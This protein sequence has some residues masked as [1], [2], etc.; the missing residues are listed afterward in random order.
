MQVCLAGPHCASALADA[1]SAIERS[2]ADNHVILLKD[3]AVRT[4]LGLFALPRGPSATNSG[5]PYADAERI[6][7]RGPRRFDESVVIAFFKYNSAARAFQP[8]P[9]KSFTFTTDAAI[10]KK[11]VY[12]RAKQITTC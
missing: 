1:L 11:N 9:S 7:G 5:G 10:I 3:D 6:Y 12:F 4:F 8:L 2:E